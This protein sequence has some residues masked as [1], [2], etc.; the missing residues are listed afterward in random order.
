MAK[1]KTKKKVL[2][3]ITSGV[4]SLT[5]QDETMLKTSKALS[6]IRQD[7]WYNMASGLGGLNNMSDKISQNQVSWSPVGAIEAEAIMSGDKIARAVVEQVVRSAL[8][9]GFRIKLQDLPIDRQV[10][11]QNEFK[12]QILVPFEIMKQ[13]TNAAT[14][15]RLYGSAYILVNVEDG[16][17]PSEPVDYDNIRTVKW[18]RAMTP[19]EL[20]VLEKNYSLDEEYLE[21]EWYTFV[22]Y[23]AEVVEKVHR[24]RVIR[25]IGEALPRHL[26]IANHY[27]HDSVL[28]NIYAQLSNYALAIQSIGFGV[29]EFSQAVFKIKGL[30]QLILSGNADKVIERMQVMN[31]SRSLV[32]AIVL[33]D[34][35]DF[36]RLSGKFNGL[37]ELI[38]QLKKDLVARTN[39]PHNIL[40][41]D[42]AGHGG[43]MLSSGANGE[44]ERSD[45]AMEVAEYQSTRL[46]SPLMTLLKTILC[47][48]DITLPFQGSLDIENLE[49]TFQNDRP[50]TPKE[51]AESYAN[52][53]AT[54]AELVREGILLPAEVRKSRF[55]DDGTF[56]KFNI[57][58]EIGSDEDYKKELEEKQKMA[59][60][61]EDKEE[62][63][64]D[65]DKGETTGK[66]NE[67][68]EKEKQE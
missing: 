18:I 9:N 63:D 25:F 48:K 35:E 30:S 50:M 67:N 37:D 53:S 3:D 22:S 15:G 32:R 16:R 36:D 29:A 14:W 4:G 6:N 60:K 23:G 8:Y 10:K 27:K 47:S 68:K 42:A 19:V 43:S 54:D 34:T 55:S 21:P 58:V 46:K 52:I 33:D 39:I 7:Q 40:F 64:D 20:Y 45:W 38:D 44:S 49:I 51:E 28:N 11:F 1:R 13:V 65:A 26:Y 57:S 62:E 17:H 41:N 66:D 24:T 59:M 5:K 31:Q 61:G 12:K 56:S 2:G